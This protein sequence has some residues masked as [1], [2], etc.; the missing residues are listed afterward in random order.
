M[1]QW[2]QQEQQ[3]QQ[4]H[5]CHI[6]ETT[7]MQTT[8]NNKQL[9]LPLWKYL[10]FCCYCWRC[11]CCC[12]CSVIV[13]SWTY[14]WVATLKKKANKRQVKGVYRSVLF[15]SQ[16][17]LFSVQFLHKSSLCEI[18]MMTRHWWVA[19][20]PP[21]AKNIQLNRQQQLKQ[22]NSKLSKRPLTYAG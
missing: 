19:S 18:R 8:R 6:T 9:N 16:P 2:Q 14:S 5:N 3:K 1:W 4:Q 20:C 11:C 7:S 22:Q 21:A 10:S 12:I 15:Q 17:S 13:K